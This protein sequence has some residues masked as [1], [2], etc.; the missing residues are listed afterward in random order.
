MDGDSKTIVWN[1]ENIPPGVRLVR[2]PLCG[3]ETEPVV[4]NR[5]ERCAVCGAVIRPVSLEPGDVLSGQF[6]IL[7]LLGEGGYGKVFLVNPLDDPSQRYV[8]KSLRTNAS[9]TSVR[10]FIREANILQQI[11]H[12]CIVSPISFWH[13]DYGYFLAM[14]Y[15]NGETLTALRKRVAFD[16]ESTLIIVKE[17]AKT[18]QYMWSEHRL[19]HRDIKPSNIMLDEKNHIK[20]L[21]FGM[22]KCVDADQTA[23]TVGRISMG[24]P[25]YM[26]PEQFSDPQNAG[27]QSDMFSLGA[28]MFFLL[29]GNVPFHGRSLQDLYDDTLHN[30]PPDIRR[31]C[32]DLSVDTEAL[33]RGMM[34]PRPCDRFPSWEEVAVLA[35]NALQ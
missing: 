33:M 16:E 34:A 3:K 26:S 13:D 11:R 23:L 8:V 17:I 4:S 12:E 32:P 19:I 5:V 9:D 1:A 6:R 27:I 15:I 18:L 25:G 35:R 28:T 31:F 14:E 20:L 29:T 21:D 30:S 2:C 10:R 7:K 24:T 22:S